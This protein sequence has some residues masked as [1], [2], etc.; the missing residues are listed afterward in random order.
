MA[1][2]KRYIQIS[3]LLYEY[4]NHELDIDLDIGMHDASMHNP[5]EYEINTLMLILSVD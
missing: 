1:F 3:I 4:T 5:D 2:V